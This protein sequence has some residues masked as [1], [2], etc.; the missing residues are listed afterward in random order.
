[1][2]F[3]GLSQTSDTICIPKKD[4]I[5]LLIRSQEWKL[6][7]EKIKLLEDQSSLLTERIKE[8]DQQIA[9]YEQIGEMNDSLISNYKKEIEVMQDQRKLY[10]MAVADYK[11]QVRIYKRKLFWRTAGGV[12][13]IAGVSYLYFTK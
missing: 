12:T 11:K 10:D 1:M 6:F 4:A 2:S 5:K 7:G 3:A 9:A 8:K 13:V